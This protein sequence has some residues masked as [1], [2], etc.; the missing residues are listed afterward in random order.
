M[1]DVINV[2]KANSTITELMHVLVLDKKTED[3]IFDPLKTFSTSLAQIAGANVKKTVQFENDTKSIVNEFKH[4][5]A[6]T[7]TNGQ[8]EKRRKILTAIRRKR[9]ALLAEF[10]P[11]L[12]DEHNKIHTTLKLLSAINKRIVL[13]EV[14]DSFAT[15]VLELPYLNSYEK[16]VLKSFNMFRN[17]MVHQNTMNVFT[18]D[19]WK[20]IEKNL[21]SVYKIMTKLAIDF[22]EKI[23][24]KTRSLEFNFIAD[25]GFGEVNRMIDEHLQKN[26]VYFLDKSI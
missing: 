4:L 13:T 1:F 6:N 25:F 12:I 9:N 16:S 15:L 23:N 19:H 24:E 3:L 7:P 26:A 18:S 17:M 10:I 8:V 14:R 11:T 21:V 20:E 2:L 22:S 5:I